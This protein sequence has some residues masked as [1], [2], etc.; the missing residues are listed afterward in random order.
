MGCASSRPAVTEHDA[1]PAGWSAHSAQALFKSK[2][3]LLGPAE[4]PLDTKISASRHGLPSAE[5]PIHSEVQRS[6]L[7]VV[8]QEARQCTRLAKTGADE[9][10][11]LLHR[12][13]QVA[14]EALEASIQVDLPAWR[15]FV[16]TRLV[17]P[18]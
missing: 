8:L 1:P 14:V 9:L 16:L 5:L 2:D 17:K 18:H 7:S 15:V 10:V 3:E 6:A 4:N 12:D 11:D 13:H